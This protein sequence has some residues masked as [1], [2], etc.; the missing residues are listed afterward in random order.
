MM[1]K[2]QSVNEVLDFAISKEIEAHN[3]YMELSEW[4]ERPEVADAFKEFAFEESRHKEKLEAIKAG[5][6][7]VQE[8]EVGSLNIADSAE[9]TEPQA[10]L[11]YPEALI[12]A[13]QR[14]KESFKLY[15]QLASISGDKKIRDIL[16]NLAMEEARHKLHLEIEY[17]LTT[18]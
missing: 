16:S 8:D 15:T 12:L 2:F 11:T 7:A 14:E 17:D 18:F 4:A 1:K 6:I 9:I 13:M 10:N 5:E 3:F